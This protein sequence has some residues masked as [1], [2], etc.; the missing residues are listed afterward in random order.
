M[1]KKRPHQ[2][3]TA[4]ET[5]GSSFRIPGI[6]P[7]NKKPAV[8]LHDEPGVL[9]HLSSIAELPTGGDEI[10]NHYHH[11]SRHPSPLLSCVLFASAA[12]RVSEWVIRKDSRLG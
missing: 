1:K 11:R 10:I 4:T 9:D 8:L 12:E 7:N 2:T 6:K 3:V 5:L